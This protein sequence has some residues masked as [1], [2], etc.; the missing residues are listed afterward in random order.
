M[1]LQQVNL[2]NTLAEIVASISYFLPELALIIL[3]VILILADLIFRHPK[4]SLFSG[5]SLIGLVVTLIFLLL[6]WQQLLELSAIDLFINMIR[7]DGLAVLLKIIF[8]LAGMASIFLSL[9]PYEEKERVRQTGS[10]YIIFSGLILGTF[11]MVMANNLLMVYISIELVSLSSYLLTNFR[12]DKNSVEAGLKYLLY[13]AVASGI[14][15]YGISLLYGL[16]G[17]LGLG[18]NLTA[19]HWIPLS[20]AVLMIAGGV[21]FKLS[22]V[23]FHIWAPDVYHGAPLPT[24]AFFSIAPKLA[25]LVV[26]VRIVAGF[27]DLN[28]PEFNWQLVLSIIAILTIIVG[29]FSAL[30]Q[31][32]IKRMMAYS[33]I[34][35]GGF[36]LAGVVASSTFGLRA[37]LFYAAVYLLMNLAAFIL[38]NN[39][40][41]KTGSL[42]IDDFKGLGKSY[43]YSGILFVLTMIALTGL[44]P[45]AGFTAKL[46]IF[47]SLWESYQFSE[48][49]FLLYLLIIGL[50]N[51]VVS[52][53]YYLKIPYYMFFKNQGHHETMVKF[54]WGEN[55]L[56]SFMIFLILL[57]FFKSEW[58]LDIINSITFVL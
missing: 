35:H 13:G 45:T 34:A 57:L 36:L 53:F 5:I 3:L 32:N 38:L 51:T 23:P 52:L 6:Q 12:F 25:G 29:N 44:P 37:L 56:A 2:S 8:C 50:F 33:S 40:A 28:I 47:S 24:V 15:L 14:M 55:I 42:I 21:L 30:W 54:N 9:Y 26:L 41:K 16:T 48:E 43:P 49:N 1:Q 20:V 11:L 31:Q 58:L 17:T 18:M 46:L 19:I 39:L 27:R 7:L 22:A 4:K 10:Y